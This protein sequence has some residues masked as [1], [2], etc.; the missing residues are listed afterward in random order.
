MK[1]KELTEKQIRVLGDLLQGNSKAHAARAA[2]VSY[3]TVWRWL[4]LEQ[5]DAVYSRARAAAEASLG[6]MV[7]NATQ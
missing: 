6:E 5:V 3:M 7:H 4:Q 2:G 1:Y